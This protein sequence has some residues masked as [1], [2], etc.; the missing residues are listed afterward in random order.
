MNSRLD[1]TELDISEAERGS[2]SFNCPHCQTEL[3]FKIKHKV[4]GVYTTQPDKIVIVD[5]LTTVERGIIEDARKRGIL[6]AFD[7]A[8]RVATNSPPNDFEQAFLTFL[9]RA[10]KIRTPQFALRECLDPRDAEGDL[11]L[12]THSFV[13]VVLADGEFRSFIPTP[14]IKGNSIGT[15][16]PVKG[17]IKAQQSYHTATDWVK[18]RFGYVQGHGALFNEMRK[19]AAGDF[20]KASR[21][22]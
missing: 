20:A 8:L 1:Y 10:N 21:N 3:Q 18:T 6:Q 17:N 9:S 12:Y 4:V 7:A 13:S 14:L 16:T 5:K 19:K 2:E 22:F 15:L 11:E